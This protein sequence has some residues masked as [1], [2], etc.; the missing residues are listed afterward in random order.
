MNLQEA[1]FWIFIKNYSIPFL[2]FLLKILI[3]KTTGKDS[4]KL[5]KNLA[6]KL[7]FSGTI[8]W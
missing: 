5:Q 1:A 6:K 7:I 2:L 4:K 3:V 8:F